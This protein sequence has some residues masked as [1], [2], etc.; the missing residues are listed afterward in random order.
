MK[1]RA[2]HNNFQLIRILVLLVAYSS[3]FVDILLIFGLP[4]K[5]ICHNFHVFLYLNFKQTLVLGGRTLRQKKAFENFLMNVCTSVNI[6]QF[7]EEQLSCC[8]TSALSCL[9]SS[10]KWLAEDTAVSTACV[11]ERPLGHAGALEV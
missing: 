9:R 4:S 11:S 5:R 1:K 3:L 2:E 6:K 10:S 7:T 8:N